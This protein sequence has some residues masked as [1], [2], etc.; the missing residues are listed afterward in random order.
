MYLFALRL[1][2]GVLVFYLKCFCFTSKIFGC[3]LECNLVA[4]GNFVRRQ[5]ETHIAFYRIL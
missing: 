4:S 3:Y 5:I 1:V 2:H